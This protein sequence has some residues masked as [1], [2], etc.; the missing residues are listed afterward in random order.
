MKK[1]FTKLIGVTLGLAMAVGVG[2][3]ANNRAATGLD[4]VETTATFDVGDFD[5]QGTANTGSACSATVGSITIST[6]KG[7]GTTQFRVYKNGSFS[8]T[9][10][11]GN[12]SALS[13][14]FSGTYTGGL[15]ESYTGLSTK[16]WSQASLGSQARFLEIVVTY[17]NGSQQ[18]DPSLSVSP[19]S[20]V[21]AKN[22]TVNLTATAANGT[23]S[24][25]WVSNGTSIATVGT[26]S[27]DLNKNVT[28]TGVSRG[29]TTVTAS[30]STADSVNVPITVTDV[31]HAGTEGD[32]YTVEDARDQ[33]DL[34]TGLSDV[35][36]TGIVSEIVTPYS[37]EHGNISYNI[38][39]DGKTT[40]EQLQAFRGKGI[41][42]ASFVSEDDIEVGATVVVTGTLVKYNSTYEFTQDNQLVSYTPAPRYTVS[43]NSL[44]GNSIDPIGNVKKG[45]CIETLPE[46][47]K[48]K[49]TEHQKRFEFLGWYTVDD[50]NNIVFEEEN[51][52][53]TSTPVNGNVTVY[54]KYNEI[55][56]YIVSFNTNGGTAIPTQ[57]VDSGETVLMPAN[58]EKAS[59]GSY[60]YTFEGW[61][62]NQGLT[63][64]FDDSDPVTSNLNLYAKYTSEAIT[65]PDSYL[66]HATS[67]ATIHGT[68]HLPNEVTVTKTSAELATA[69]GWTASA[70]QDI[71][72]VF[73]SFALDSNITVGFSGTGNTA[74]YWTSG[75]EIR[76]YGTKNTSDASIT[77]TGG[78]GVTIN[79]ITLT[80]GTSNSPTF[81][82][83]ITTGTA[84]SVNANS[85]TITMNSGSKNG[86]IKITAISVD[87]TEGSYSV[88]GVVLRFGA[89]IAKSDWDAINNNIGHPDW[90]ITDYGVMFLKEET[91][92]GYGVSSVKAA[93]ESNPSKPVTIKHKGSGEAPYLNGDNYLFTIKVSIPAGY[94]G[95][96]I[97]AAPFIK[98]NDTY[99]FLGEEKHES[100]NS[101]AT[102][103]RNNGGSNL[104]NDAL[105]Y[106]KTAH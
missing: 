3:A 49:D 68:E 44:G 69:N 37:E 62:T 53:T 56:Y 73:N 41:G 82:P 22:E 14:T 106:L 96:V 66:T 29:K 34:N 26:P 47:T 102:Y 25:S 39:S 6:N 61:Y 15:Q 100:V 83:S 86:Q 99:Y 46:P 24:V 64:E 8:I 63:D 93:F 76:V 28:V 54:A 31:Q 4:A 17:D 71:G 97:C 1:I 42:G 19:T 13:F 43:F 91:M 81:T 7:Y 67:V 79:S 58:P 32:P 35:Y 10:S 55:S 101:L 20:A 89:S 40:S 30:Y 21:I 95:D 33:I 104:S 9:S 51:K 5:G 72:T 70:N 77:F 27:G 98:V 65:N 78:T 36:V 52:F 74:S 23:G 87:Y 59:D 11:A 38:S 45:T 18:A 50:P 94:Y 88:D 57:E 80:F 90:E 48:A 12:I 84:L 75:T 16:T 92:N 105:D 2:V 85:Q 103:Y 60:T